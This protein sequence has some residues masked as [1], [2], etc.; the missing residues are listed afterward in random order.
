MDSYIS[1]IGVDFVSIFLIDSLCNVH[2]VQ[3]SISL[4]NYNFFSENSDR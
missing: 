3:N 1:T 2:I 4:I